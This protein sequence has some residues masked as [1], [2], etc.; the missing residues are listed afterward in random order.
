MA[1]IAQACHWI[2]WLPIGPAPETLG[3]TMPPTVGVLDWTPIETSCNAPN[4]VNDLR[5]EPALLLRK[6]ICQLL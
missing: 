2:G 4:A 5:R 6:M 1:L 3:V